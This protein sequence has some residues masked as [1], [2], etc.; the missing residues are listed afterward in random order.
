MT[1]SA[2]YGALSAPRTT[3]LWRAREGSRL[4]IP[5]LIPEEGQNE[6]STYAQP[7]QSVGARCVAGLSAQL[8]LALFPPNVPFY[9]LELDETTAA[10]LGT[11]LGEANEKLAVIARTAYSLMN[12]T[13]LG[14][15]L[16]ELIRHL[17][18]AGNV[19]LYL[20]EDE[21]PRLFR[22]DQ[23]VVKRDDCGDLLEAVVKEEIYPSAL[24]PETR[25]AVGLTDADPEKNEE[26]VE[27]F[28][29]IVREGG[30]V[31]WHQEIKGTKVPSSEGTAPR[32]S[33]PWLALRWL[34]IPGNDW[35]R[36]HVTEYI[37]DLW[38]LEDLS[39]AMVQFAAEAARI[40]HIVDPNSGID[41]EE[42][43]SAETGDYLNGYADRV[44]TLQLDKFQDWGVINQLAERIEKRVSD[45]FLLRS[46]AVRNAER[47]TAEEVR[48]VAQEL[49]TT[50]GGTY[51]VLAAELQL[52]LVRR[53]LYI[54]ARKQAIPKLPKAVQPKVV[55]GF[56]ALGRTASVQRIKMWAADLQAILGPQAV[57]QLI[58]GD[59]LSKRLGEGYGVEG[60]KDLVKAP[61]QQQ[62]EQQQGTQA[63]VMAAAA[64]HIVKGVVDAAAQNQTQ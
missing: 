1:A 21:R 55:T 15:I 64:P 29:H 33:S 5:G 44:K 7:Y 6:H 38:S 47:V 63:Q 53:F 3:V 41:V 42:L 25:L 32:D 52:P 49:E 43:A 45:A 60:L 10:Q 35:G 27:V 17:I 19:L 34:A 62:Q 54:G 4:T 57:A 13:S 36:G 28:T 20:P 30:N 8:L 18:V 37:G 58:N 51:T 16:G 11:Q 40:I 56:D 12:G 26:K 24:D 14:A 48:G 39:K 9:K 50:L 23:Y 31:K 61:E 46:G 22:I 2:R 59:E